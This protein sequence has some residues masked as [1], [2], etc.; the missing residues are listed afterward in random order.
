VAV[1]LPGTAAQAAG[2]RPGDVLLALDGEAVTSPLRLMNLVFSRPAGERIALRIRRDG[3][4][5][6]L[7]FPLGERVDEASEEE[8]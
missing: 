8:R 7:V 3:A 2:L 1:V 5:R 4:E 6:I